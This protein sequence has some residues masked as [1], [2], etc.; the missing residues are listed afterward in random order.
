MA[1]YNDPNKR[2]SARSLLMAAIAGTGQYE[3]F[4]TTPRAGDKCSFVSCIDGSTDGHIWTIECIPSDFVI[5]DG[6]W[7]VAKPTLHR[8]DGVQCWPGVDYFKHCG[9]FAGDPEWCMIL[10]RESKQEP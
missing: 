6:S 5:V 10:K 1:A 3:P 8:P 7:G 9:F 4:G 2:P